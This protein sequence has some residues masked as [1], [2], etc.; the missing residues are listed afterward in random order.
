[1]GVGGVEMVIVNDHEEGITT[2]LPLLSD[3][4]TSSTDDPWD[5]S[6]LLPRDWR[7]T[8]YNCTSSTYVTTWE[9][10]L[11]LIEAVVFAGAVLI[12][13]AVAAYPAYVVLI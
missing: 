2:S 4:D 7:D 12:I 10:R 6:Q 13:I 3:S 9:S 1:M 11:R 5:W 8:L